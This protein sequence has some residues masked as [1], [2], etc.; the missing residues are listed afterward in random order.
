MWHVRSFIKILFQKC[1][2]FCDFR[3]QSFMLLGKFPDL[4]LEH[5]DDEAN[6]W[7]GARLLRPRRDAFAL[8]LRS[9]CRELMRRFAR[10]KR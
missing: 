8:Y 5:R 3:S 7:P 6:Y 9:Q 2:P 10:V 1:C 4:L